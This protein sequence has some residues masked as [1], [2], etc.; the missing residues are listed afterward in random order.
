MIQWLQHCC[1]EVHRWLS[2]VGWGICLGSRRTEWQNFH[3]HKVLDMHWSMSFWIFSQIFIPT[4][5]MNSYL[6]QGGL[7]VWYVWWLEPIHTHWFAVSVCPFLLIISEV[8]GEI[9]LRDYTKFKTLRTTV[10]GDNSHVSLCASITIKK[11]WMWIR[12]SASSC[13]QNCI[14]WWMCH[15][16]QG[17][18]KYSRRPCSNRYV[19]SSLLW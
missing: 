5:H 18:E 1:M 8:G 12:M 6:W 15:T 3:H 13:H 10:S 11:N 2:Q 14:L 9:H 17:E 4:Q 7:G 16:Q 19:I